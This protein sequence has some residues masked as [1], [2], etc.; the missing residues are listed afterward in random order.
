MTSL[1]LELINLE[2]ISYLFLVL[3]LLKLSM[4][5]FAGNSLSCGQE[6]LVSKFRI[7]RITVPDLLFCKMQVNSSHTVAKNNKMLQLIH[8]LMFFQ[9]QI[10]KPKPLLSIVR[11][12][13]LNQYKHQQLSRLVLSLYSPAGFTTFH[14]ILIVGSPCK[15]RL[16]GIIGQFFLQLA[17]RLLGLLLMLPPRPFRERERVEVGLVCL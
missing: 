17:N 2:H 16:S 7:P 8:E 3:L 4:Y 15:R 12:L 1:M 13:I 14:A 5:F 9:K 11:F 6:L 10:S